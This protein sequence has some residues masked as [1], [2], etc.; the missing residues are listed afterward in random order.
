MLATIHSTALPTEPTTCA[1][2]TPG[3]RARAKT[4]PK[5]RATPK[6]R[7]R[8]QARRDSRRP[9][10]E[11]LAAF[12]VALSEVRLE[13]TK[14]EIKKRHFGWGKSTTNSGDS[15]VISKS[16]TREESDYLKSVG[17]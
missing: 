4:P 11:T 17:L 13:Q 6:R 1:E 2:H 8:E 9:P 14:Q 16:Y 12:A 7:E 3:R 5:G 10:E 15:I